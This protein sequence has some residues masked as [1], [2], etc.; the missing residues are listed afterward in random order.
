[1]TIDPP[2]LRLHNKHTGEVLQMWREK[3]DDETVLQLR[4]TLPPHGQG[5]PLH[6]HHIEDEGGIV[7][8]GVLAA[9]VSGRQLTFKQGETVLLPHGFPHRWWNGG[10]EL[11]RFDGHARPLADLDRFLQAIFEVINAGPPNRPPVFYL[12]HALL[13]H[14]R[15]Q[16]ILVVPPM[17]QAVLFRVIVAVGMLLGRYRGTEWPGCPARC[18]GAPERVAVLN[19]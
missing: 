18:T 5:P 6:I 12:A 14:R 9:E 16:T 11:L 3:R 1:M 7:T 17:V 19:A 15:T 13:R 8:A 4:G 2:T 10:D